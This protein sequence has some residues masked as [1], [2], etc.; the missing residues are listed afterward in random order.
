MRTRTALPAAASSMRRRARTVWVVAL[1]ALM[2]AGCM[3]AQFGDRKVGPDE[4]FE[5]SRP[6]V[7]IVEADNAVT[8]SVPQPELSPAKANQL[9]DRLIAMVRAGQVQPTQEAVEQAALDLI[10]QDPGSWFSAG[11][12][13]FEHTD[14]VLV[15]GSGFFVSEDGY[16]LTNDHV[17]ETTPDDIKRLMLAGGDWASTNP[18][19]EMLAGMREGLPSGVTISDEQAL[20][21]LRWSLDSFKTDLRID[22]V[23]RTYRVGF[24]SM[25]PDEVKARGT[26]A[27]VVAHGGATPERDV[28]VLK[29]GGGPY[30]SLAM[31]PSV[32]ATNAQLT[33]IGY[34]CQCTD[35]TTANP[36]LTLAPVQTHGRSRGRVQMSTGWS[37]IATDVHAEHGNSGGPLIDDS[38]HVVGVMTFIDRETAA[39]QHSF[40]VPMDVVRQF[41]NQAGIKPVQGPLGQRYTLAIAEFR[42]QHYR[43][44]LP[45]FQSVSGA[46]S[47]DPSVQRYISDSSRAIAAGRD[48]TP[49]TLG[50]LLPYGLV[51][52]GALGALTVLAIGTTVVVRR[53]RR[54]VV[55]AG[56]AANAG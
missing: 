36:G 11:A 54:R 49:P 53:R 37:A 45:L 15:V 26:A 28:A 19:P 12:G 47:G 22:S 39:G 18:T 4:I 14:P 55:A 34:P 48:R 1:C 41:T 5:A 2:F 20:R 7:V 29:V 25:T 43:R 56:P 32:P 10:L 31:A 44:A 46:M 42:Q 27:Q 38:G 6:A 21:L 17:V 23:Q 13:R 33:A 51:V 16:L 24:G 9:Q 8:W 3:P 40:A 52:L 35:A 50:Q 30:A